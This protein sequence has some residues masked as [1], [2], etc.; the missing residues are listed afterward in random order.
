MAD[1][2]E[3]LNKSYA[4][5]LTAL[6]AGDAVGA[7]RRLRAIQE[8]A[9][10][11]VNSLRLLG[12][13]LL[14]QEK[15][16]A[17]VET[18]Q[19]AVAVAP[20]FVHARTDLARA[21]RQA[22]RLDAAHT[23]LQF[24]LNDAPSLAPA[25]VV[26]GDVLVD[27]QDYDGARAA[28]R[29]AQ[30]EDPQASRL[31]KARAQ[32]GRGNRIDAERGFRAILRSDTSHIG[33]LCGLAALSLEAGIVVDAERL[34]R[35]ALKQTAHSPLVWR[36]LA[37]VF[38]EAGRL[39]EAEAAVRRA[40]LVE[41]ESAQSWIVLAS[42]SGRLMRPEA[43]LEAYQTAER[44][45]PKQRL[46]HLSVGHVLKSLGRRAECERTYHE[47]IAREP[48]LAEA[49]WSLAD[50]K[51][52]KFSD[53]EILAMEALL[54]A[55]TG[56]QANAALL[57]FALGRAHEQRGDTPRAFTHYTAGNRLRRE[58]SPFDF[59]LFERKSRRVI[60]R[61]RKD[62]FTAVRGSGCPDR[63]PIFIVGMPRSGSTL[64][65]QILA[66]HPDV[67]GTMEL[68]NILNYVRELDC[69]DA[70]ADAYP[71]SLRSAP[72]AVLAALGRRYMAETLPLRHGRARFIDKQPNNFSHVGFIHAILPN[73]TVI[74]VRRHPM[75]ACFSCFKQYFAA[76]QSFTYDLEGLGRY[77]RCYL[78]LMDHWDAV[79]PGKVLHLSYEDLILDPEQNIGRLLAHCGLDFDPRC[80]QF[81][82]TRRPIRTA[83]SEQV[84]QPLY[85]SGVGYWKRFER[86]LEP[87]RRSLGE[88]LDRFA[89][90]DSLPAARRKNRAGNN[91]AEI[92][93]GT[94]TAK[95]SICAPTRMVFG[96]PPSLT[97]SPRRAR[98]GV[99]VAIAALL[100][101]GCHPKEAAADSAADVL[102]EVVVTARKRSENLQD[103]PQNI[104]VYTSRDLESL[105]ITQL[106]DYL[107]L[108]PSL[109]FISTGPDQQRFFI[110]GAS[111]GSNPN[112]GSA[113]VSTTAYLIDDLS[114]GFYGRIPDMHLYDV[115]RIEILNGPQG[116]L[117]GA[118]ALSGAVRVVTKKPDPGAFAAGVDI[119]GGQIDGGANNWSYE[120]FVN[121]PLVDGT[122]A[123]RL[124]A[125]SV[126][127][128]GYIDNVLGTRHWLNGT[129]STNA[130]WAGDN[131]NTSDIVGG[132]IA[133]Q[134][135]FT[136]DWNLTLTGTFQR[137]VYRG[138]WEED[139]ARFGALNVQLFSPQGGYDYDRFLDLHVEGDAGIGDLVYAGGYSQRRTRRLYDYSDYAQYNTYATSIQAT[140]CA[141]D[142][143]N[144]TG[145]SG[146]SVPYMYATTNSLLERWSNELRLQS[147]AG[148]RTHWT[149]G[150][151][152]ER[153]RNPYSGFIAMPGI[154][155]KGEQANYYDLSHATPLPQEWYSDY[156]TSDRLQ[157]TEFADLTFDLDQRWSV[158]AGI[159]HY[160]S[161]ISELTDWAGYYYEPKIPV[162]RTE[163]AHKTNFKAGVD[164]K[165][166]DHLLLYFSFAQGF[167][168]G[169]FNYMGAAAPASLPRSFMPDTINNYEL[170]WKTE[171]LNG[172]VVW[173]GALYYM[174]W[175]N[176]QV[177]VSWPV[178]PFGFNANI[179]DARIEGIE[180]SVEVHPIAGLQLSLS[181]DYNDSTLVSDEFRNPS[182]VVV[183]GERLPE[184]PSFNMNAIS[185][186]EWPLLQGP[187]AF[188]QFDIA[189]KGSM[190][191]DLRLDHRIVQPAYTIGDLR[192]GLTQPKGLWQAEAYVTNV[193]NTRAV[194]FAD[195]NAD[196]HPVNP[197]IPNEPR[198]FGLRLKYRWGKAD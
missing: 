108:A 116:T 31:A 177:A 45:D 62:F 139:P 58:A 84:R 40:L 88:C 90:T 182:Y 49:Y 111:D 26:L 150:A 23:E 168:D 64:V 170:G 110:R 197:D 46:A 85:A 184:A 106:E 160:R 136:S 3:N 175:K 9:A 96:L 169:G 71:D 25:W 171:L 185:R 188:A 121:V 135:N 124:S 193:W 7:E 179:G 162:L 178:A 6:R 151:Y 81:H 42:V 183:P 54:T 152:W 103:V 53:A 59:A 165:A 82:E 69:L 144:G 39:V 131:Y 8:T 1:T 147:K 172:R 112:F 126:Q 29:R 44:L 157:T 20:D 146:C 99:G 186:Y 161:S 38:L 92:T 153:T 43:A 79:L 130:A 104:D 11:N 187:R 77:Y 167:R 129:T 63:G 173:N 30:A 156:A 134:Q 47:C 94:A 141:T 68:P 123:L 100:Y 52:Y 73:A 155:L 143:I 10:G 66:S 4:L 89:S 41:P 18:L 154:N 191:N 16:Q 120:G 34:L 22:G 97:S 91:T 80:L 98:S 140:A 86:D 12:L 75:D 2:Q 133:L 72:S 48:E 122:T 101:G 127:K 128:G 148:G 57:S 19:Q 27:R 78:E 198:V 137:Q 95:M 5:A 180:S 37:Q 36:A 21:Y 50:L 195:Y 132:R 35:H 32:F 142:P 56:G 93:D 118:G 17:A 163:S 24:V 125:Y 107:T 113:N 60:G 76:G 87:L 109:S 117:F 114:L 33:A 164:F 15:D 149:V 115:E 196:S 176:Y 181:G 65:E 174:A 14:M 102:S 166:A 70:S 13:A 28:F 61:L 145:Y 74:D 55:G 189:H 159:D 119:D 83:S 105:H 138:S 158:E 194:I 67:E 190:W 192:I 51:N